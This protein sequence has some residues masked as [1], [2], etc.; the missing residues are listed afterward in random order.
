MNG[1]SAI[2]IIITGEVQNVRFRNWVCNLADELK[3]SGW[4]KNRN[5]NSLTRSVDIYAEAEEN[6]IKEFCSQL[7]AGNTESTV[8]GATIFKVKYF[9]IKGFSVLD[10]KSEDL[11]H[12]AA[13]NIKQLTE[14]S[15]KH[16]KAVSESLFHSAGNLYRN[17]RID[18]TQAQN[19]TKMIPVEHLPEGMAR[20]FKG[21]RSDAGASFSAEMW[22][23]TRLRA[24]HSKIFGNKLEFILEDKK[25]G[26]EFA[27]SLNLRTPKV[28]ARYI[29]LD[30]I[31]FSERTVI[32][33]S[34]GGGSKAVYVIQTKNEILDLTR[35]VALASFDELREA[36]KHSLRVKHARA[37]S[38]L[39][40]EFIQNDDGS[41]PTDL[42]MLTFYGEV[43]M[44]QEAT[45]L[46]TRVCYYNR[47]GEKI[48]T[49]RYEN[50]LFPGTGLAPEYIELAERIGKKI[51]APFL[52]IDFFKSPT[53]PIFGEF[54]PRPG[55]FHQF[56]LETD[57]WL[58]KYFIRAR[59]RLLADLLAGK[60][61][62]EFKD[63]LASVTVQ[64]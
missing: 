46:P 17:S 28:L 34:R 61:F 49:G 26:L 18:D 48:K 52:R 22:A 64:K 1:E 2:R 20:S 21:L 23:Q 35:S 51:P 56:N 42:K 29:P 9:G 62:F 47:N 59:A 11:S 58:G 43:A 32:K 24:E 50:K 36:M 31:E 7:I 57:R 12:G 30:D 55:N 45:R 4:I 38:W 60:D 16:S 41:I 8:E 27:K 6:V 13:E 39:I 14:L 53:G 37:D 25:N 3:V 63:F 40:E 10:T 54:T 5:L 15:W 44:V 19:F 33:P